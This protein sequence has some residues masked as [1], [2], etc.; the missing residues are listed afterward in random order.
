[1]DLGNTQLHIYMYSITMCKTHPPLQ[2]LKD[3]GEDGL[4]GESPNER[5]RVLLKHAT[6]LFEFSKETKHTTENTKHENKQGGQQT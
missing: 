5:V 6:D 2:L 3:I 1:M 4:V